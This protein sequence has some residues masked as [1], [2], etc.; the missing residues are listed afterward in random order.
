[1]VVVEST[2]RVEVVEVGSV[3]KG[4]ANGVSGEPVGNGSGAGS[5]GGRSARSNAKMANGSVAATRM[6]P[7]LK[8]G[9]RFLNHIRRSS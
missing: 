4:K 5:S 6:M 8:P 1:V 2:G 7:S 3:P 9:W